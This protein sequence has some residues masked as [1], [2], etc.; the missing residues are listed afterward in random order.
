MGMKNSSGK[1]NLL[2]REGFYVVLFLCLCVVAVL[3]VYI[4]KTN[5]LKNNQEIAK[6]QVAQVEEKLQDAELLGF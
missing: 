1:S 6:N 5:S 2:K 4:S 3:T